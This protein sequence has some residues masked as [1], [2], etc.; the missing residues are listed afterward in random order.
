MKIDNGLGELGLKR[1]EAIA[2]GHCLFWSWSYAQNVSK[3]I[4]EN[5]LSQELLN[6]NDLI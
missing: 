2:D 4:L 1:I 5:K 3:E 6:N